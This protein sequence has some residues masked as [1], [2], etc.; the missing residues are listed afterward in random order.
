MPALDDRTTAFRSTVIY[1]LGGGD[2]GAAPRWN[3]RTL[4][5]TLA[6]FAPVRAL[7]A[8]RGWN[9]EQ[10]IEAWLYDDGAAGPL[11]ACQGRWRPAVGALAFAPG[12][13]PSEAAS[14]AAYNAYVRPLERA[15]R[16]RSKAVTHRRTILTW[17]I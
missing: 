11:E 8:R 7:A 3:P 12:L 10:M 4:I 16:T 13:V 9:I 2:A 1:N 15:H 17:A 6:S 5:P 14:F